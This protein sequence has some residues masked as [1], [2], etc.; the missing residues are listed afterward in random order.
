MQTITIILILINNNTVCVKQHNSPEPNNL[1]TGLPLSCYKVQ[2]SDLE[3]G[4]I[5]H[6]TAGS[7]K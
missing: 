4:K 3:S 6:E 5:G 2:N 1:I 7:F